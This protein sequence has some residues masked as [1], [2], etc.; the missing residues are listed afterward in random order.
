MCPLP[1]FDALA[2]YADS[3]P[4]FETDRYTDRQADGRTDVI[5]VRQTRH[6]RPIL[7]VALKKD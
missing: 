3:L 5:L 6:A 2:L 7:H 4:M 1:L